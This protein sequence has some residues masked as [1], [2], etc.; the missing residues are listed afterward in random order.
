MVPSEMLSEIGNT[1]VTLEEVLAHMGRR[2]AFNNLGFQLRVFTDTT[3]QVTPSHALVGCCKIK[4]YFA[5]LIGYVQERQGE[6]YEAF[7][8]HARLADIFFL[9]HVT[10]GPAADLLPQLTAS[11]PTVVVF[12]SSPRLHALARLGGTPVAQPRHAQ[13]HQV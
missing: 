8:R 6:D 9:A 4:F 5:F 13:A 1:D 7:A 10:G 2:L 12:D 3:F 11:A